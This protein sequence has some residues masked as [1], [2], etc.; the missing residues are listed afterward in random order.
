MGRIERISDDAIDDA[1]MTRLK[2]SA[3]PIFFF[4]FFCCTWIFL[5][6]S[7]IFFH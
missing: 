2:P 7:R 6:K 3:L 1:M 4:F 5:N